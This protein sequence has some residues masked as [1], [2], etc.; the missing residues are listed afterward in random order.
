M[1]N[2]QGWTRCVN[3]VRWRLKPK[4]VQGAKVAASR[5]RFPVFPH[6]LTP[7]RDEL[8]PN[9]RDTYCLRIQRSLG[10][11]CQGGPSVRYGTFEGV[12]VQGFMATSQPLSTLPSSRSAWFDVHVIPTW[13]DQ[14]RPWQYISIHS[15]PRL[16]VLLNFYHVANWSSEAMTNSI[17]MGLFGNRSGMWKTLGVGNWMHIICIG[18]RFFFSMAFTSSRA[19]TAE[20][21]HLLFADDSLI[22]GELL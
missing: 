19:V 21:S 3:C 17:L 2:L 14:G 6:D 18:H 7:C 8:H 20:S 22:R 1:D 12:Q 15:R 5:V 11:R 4:F 10:G 9:C 13:R 16:I